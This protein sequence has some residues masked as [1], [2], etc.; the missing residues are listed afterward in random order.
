MFS[1]ICVP[2]YIAHALANEFL[3]LRERYTES[4]YQHN[5]L[6]DKL[7]SVSKSG[8]KD[9]YSVINE[10]LQTS[11][12]GSQVQV[13]VQ[14]L[15]LEKT[16]LEQK[17]VTL[18]TDKQ[19]LTQRKADLELDLTTAAQDKQQILLEL[20]EVKSRIQEVLDY[21][22]TKTNMFDIDGVTKQKVEEYVDELIQ[23]EADLKAT[24]QTKD[25][26]Y[27]TLKTAKE[28]AEQQLV[29]LQNK[30]STLQNEKQGVDSK[31]SKI[32]TTLSAYNID[33][34][35]PVDQI[36]GNIK[37]KLDSIGQLQAR[38]VELEQQEL[39]L[40][41]EKAT[42]VANVSNLQEYKSK[43]ETLGSQVDSIKRE[44]EKAEEI[45]AALTTNVKTVLN[46]LKLPHTSLDQNDFNK[47]NVEANKQKLGLELATAEKKR[48]GASLNN[49][50]KQLETLGVIPKGGSVDDVRIQLNNLVA[51][52]EK[53]EKEL[54][55]IREVA[56]QIRDRLDE[57]EEIKQHNASTQLSGTIIT[58]E[59]SLK[60]D[61]QNIKSDIDFLF[62]QLSTNND[63]AGKLQQIIKLNTKYKVENIVQQINQDL[64]NCTDCQQ[65]QESLTQNIGI[66]AQLPMELPQTVDAVNNDASQR[67]ISLTQEYDARVN[68]LQTTLDKCNEEI[69]KSSEIYKKI[70]KNVNEAFKVLSQ[71]SQEGDP[72]QDQDQNQAQVKLIQ[73][74]EELKNNTE[75]VTRLKEEYDYAVQYAISQ[76]KQR[77]GGN[78]IC[79]E[80]GVNDMVNKFTVELA[81]L[82]QNLDTVKSTI[83]SDQ[84]FTPE[85]K[86]NLEQRIT[87]ISNLINTFTTT[88][89]TTK[90][91]WE[92]DHQCVNIDAWKNEMTK[93]TSQVS[94]V[95]TDV[96]G[97]ITVFIKIKPISATT[98]GSITFPQAIVSEAKAEA[99][100]EAGEPK[101]LAVK[102]NNKDTK[103]N[104][105]YSIFTP[106]RS[107]EDVFEGLKETFDLLKSGYRLILFGYGST[108]SGKSTVLLGDSSNKKED[109]RKGVLIRYLESI[110]DQ[111]E[112]ISVDSIFEEGVETFVLAKSKEE[113]V[114]NLKGKVVVLYGQPP[115]IDSKF[116][117]ITNEV[118]KFQ[119]KPKAQSLTPNN[120]QTALSDLMLAIEQHRLDY[121]RIKATSFNP[122][123]SRSHLYLCFTITFK[124]IPTPSTLVVV[125]MAGSEKTTELFDKEKEEAAFHEKSIYTLLT[126]TTG[127][128]EFVNTIKEGVYIN[129]SLKHLVYHLKSKTQTDDSKRTE[130]PLAA[131]KN[132][133]KNKKE[134][135]GITFTNRLTMYEQNI[136]MFFVKPLTPEE[137]RDK[138]G[139]FDKFKGRVPTRRIFKALENLGASKK[140]KY[141]MLCTIR[142]E[143]EFCANVIDTL[144]FAKVVQST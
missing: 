71:V 5:N 90:T 114:H 31:L 48:Y 49:I 51:T 94:F 121:K 27:N 91:N 103:F 75:Y 11:N 34:N 132:K 7:T 53:L 28:T 98:P 12:N 144:D 102:C 50:L 60:K 40:I 83:Q 89:T 25:A 36:E 122:K 54:G 95:V 79:T 59:K 110:S 30:H 63:L 124:G 99:E 139:T 8:S 143:P 72:S 67:L 3:T 1:Q 119:I 24:L 47:I 64:A 62:I 73:T 70:S 130:F 135:P 105:F 56:K 107:N 41:T 96:K 111:M 133:N 125:D 126:I 4:Q 109:L 112:H 104:T 127:N 137:T 19:Q 32:V 85:A 38:V 55:E 9:P 65:Q 23:R 93:I 21:L 74:L 57:I 16:A 35:V 142:Q 58:E 97:H 68:E 13:Q 77:L 106:Q 20:D 80:D 44:K 116:T 46:T 123:S 101:A 140:T 113:G 45:L 76:L 26:E 84:S 134:D 141:V 43:F 33:I 61:L 14:A 2:N 78:L 86:T 69:Q 118:D 18:E 22:K 115:E 42:L 29:D 92:S 15:Q 100:A 66:V 117:V 52:K 128:N 108:G 37:N 138:T 6:R 88:L 82:M 39:D 131:V 120:I 87:T 81:I 136:D 129:E 10:L 17:I